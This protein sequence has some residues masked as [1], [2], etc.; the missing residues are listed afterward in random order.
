MNQ[1]YQKTLSVMETGSDGDDGKQSPL[2]THASA[3]PMS[4]MTLP[5]PLLKSENQEA[6]QQQMLHRQMSEG[7][8]EDSLVS[9]GLSMASLDMQSDSSNYFNSPLEGLAVDDTA[10]EDIAEETW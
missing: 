10:M 5:V 4:D 2:K 3:S 6:Q 7:R 1:V 9:D 8:D